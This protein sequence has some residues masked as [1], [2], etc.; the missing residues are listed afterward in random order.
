MLRMVVT[1][2]KREGVKIK[3]KHKSNNQVLKIKTYQLSQLVKVVITDEHPVFGRALEGL[4]IQV[5]GERD[6]ILLSTSRRWHPKKSRVEVAHV[7]NR[8]LPLVEGALM[9]DDFLSALWA[10]SHCIR[11]RMD[12]LLRGNV[13]AQ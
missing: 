5:A 4:P 2:W 8:K 6:G 3:L 11:Q 9:V 13:R 7:L 10:M 12:P 1:A